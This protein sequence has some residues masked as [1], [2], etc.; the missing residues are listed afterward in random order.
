M[1]P[2]QPLPEA[3]QPAALAK[4]VV[5]LTA[6]YTGRGPTKA[7]ATI[8]QDSI[9]VVLQDTLT[10]G[11]RALVQNGEADLVIAM[12]RGFQRVMEP[13]MV[14]GVQAIT[15]RQVLA[16]LSDHRVNPD[17]AVETFVLVPVHAEASRSA[18]S[19]GDEQPGMATT[20]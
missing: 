10:K 15:G 7:R 5:R 8:N 1:Q 14:D 11:E 19:R 17:V 18:E 9:S 2:A 4:L 20:A 16:F 3:D 12:R 13:A 6:E